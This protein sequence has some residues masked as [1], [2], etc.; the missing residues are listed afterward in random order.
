MTSCLPAE[1]IA[2]KL[3]ADRRERSNELRDWIARGISLLQ[4][5]SKLSA[6][7]KAEG[8]LSELQEKIDTVAKAEDIVSK[9]EETLP[10]IARLI[11]TLS[12]II[13][14]E[15]SDIKERLSAMEIRYTEE[16]LQELRTILR[17]ISNTWDVRFFADLNDFYGLL[18]DR[19][20]SVLTVTGSSQ[21]AFA[22]TVA[23]YVGWIS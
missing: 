2:H 19:I 17:L 12:K 20:N 3:A 13:Q 21:D 18:D 6:I 11:H 10:A 5:D 7:A 23:C 1:V 22:N 14:D 4:I 9:L 15:L 8:E 16:G